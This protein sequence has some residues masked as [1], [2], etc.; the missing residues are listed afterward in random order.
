V[1][2]KVSEAKSV[3]NYQYIEGLA[4]LQRA[5]INQRLKGV[6]TFRFQ[7]NV[8]ARKNIGLKSYCFIVFA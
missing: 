6:S 2:P 8:F 4:K 1:E 7:A 5:T 3:I